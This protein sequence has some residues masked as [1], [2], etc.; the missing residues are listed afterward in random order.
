MRNVFNGKF[1]L[2]LLLL[3]LSA[4]VACNAPSTAMQTP[5]PASSSPVEA[6]S[7]AS[8]TASKDDAKD[9]SGLR[10]WAGQYPF[11]RGQNKGQPRGNFLELPEIKPSLVKLLGA[12]TLARLQKGYY[13]T[14][15]IELVDENL[16]LDFPPNNH[17]NTEDDRIV[18]VINLK[19]SAMH[20]GVIKDER[21]SWTHTPEGAQI[22][23]AVLSKLNLQSAGNMDD[24]KT[25]REGD[26]VAPE[27]VI[28]SPQDNAA[29]NAATFTVRGTVHDPNANASGVANVTV[30]G[31][32]AT[33]NVMQ[34]T[35]TIEL[36]LKSGANEITVQ[37]TD[38]AGNAATKTIKVTCR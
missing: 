8:P 37:A 25:D 23:P 5:T 29:I 36:E 28:T 1:L 18:I 32:D 6:K 7:A 22:S 38:N 26:T 15:P 19:T 13:L 2:T 27:I 9:L 31:H 21:T 3:L 35:W 30:N 12:S 34:G 4:T 11:G 14:L 10:A 24:E 17:L 16:V 20:A 33:R